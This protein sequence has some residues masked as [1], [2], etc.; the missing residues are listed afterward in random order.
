MQTDFEINVKDDVPATMRDG[1]IL[2]ADIYRPADGEQRPVLLC[3]TPYHKRSERHIA[4]ATELAKRGY[5]VVVQDVRGRYSSEG[6]FLWMF[7]DQYREAEDGYD[8]VEWA[9][10]LPGSTGQVGTFGLSYDAWLQWELATLRPPHLK[11][12]VPVGICPRLLE[13]NFGIFETGRRLR[14][15]YM[16]AADYRRRAG[17]QTGP[18]SREAANEIWNDMER[19][20]WLWFLPFA[21]LPVDEIF[22]GLADQFRDYLQKQ[23]VEYWRFPEAH[24]EVDVPVL[25]I[26]G[27]YDRLIGTIDHFAGMRQNGRTAHARRNQKL[28]IGPWG[29]TTDLSRH[30]G[31]M[32]FG[33]E[34]TLNYYELVTRWFDY[35]LKGIEN[36]V[37]DEPPIRRFVMGENI[38]YGEQAWPPPNTRYT[39]YY[40]HSAGSANT[41]FGDGRL[42]HTSPVDEPTDSYLYDPRDPV[43]SLCTPDVQ[44]A[45]Y[46]QR[47]LDDRRDVLVFATEPLA[48]AIEVTGTVVV[49]LWAASTAPDTDFTAK[50]VDVH[51]D[52]FAVSLCYGIVRAQ[53]RQSYE[54]PSLITPGKVYEYT[55]SL[56]S[57]GNLF[58][59]GHRLRVDIS[60]SNFPF[61]DRNHNTGHPFFEDAELVPA[62]Q[63]IYHTAQYPSRLILPII[64]RGVQAG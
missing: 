37:M 60:S 54:T 33:M 48:Q 17:R 56:R 7:G 15:C 51:P 42:S 38:W 36:G 50:L 21:D 12:M 6:E 24:R 13:L 18:Q 57:T 58:K 32:D 46:D 4:D 64:D 52:G 41:P 29:H 61:F 26:T 20:K 22:Y 39:D 34:A 25:G 44:D 27:W 40:F 5:I 53:Y 43:M 47:P 30:V 55:I 19:E 8:T 28:L 23:D 63:T 3:R 59:P 2:R 49:K 35:W 11:A 1:T 14:W 62:T 10:T 9:A 16:M 45:P 31:A